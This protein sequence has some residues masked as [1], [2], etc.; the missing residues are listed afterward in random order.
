MRPIFRDLRFDDDLVVLRVPKAVL[1][2]TT[3][4]QS[5]DQNSDFLVNR[6]AASL[7]R[8]ERQTA[9]QSLR[10]THRSGA[11]FAQGNRVVIEAR[12]DGS[13]RLGLET[14]MTAQPRGNGR[15]RGP[16]E[17]LFPGSAQG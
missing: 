11:E 16:S 6:A 4:R 13:I 17:F 5:P 1:Q 9:R 8:S 3:P 2:K 12:E 10:A 7:K 14:D 15:W